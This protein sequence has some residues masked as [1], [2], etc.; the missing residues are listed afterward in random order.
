MMLK[1]DHFLSLI[2]YRTASSSIR[3][4]ISMGILS[5]FLL[6]NGPINIP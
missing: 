5:F 3:A 1:S 2:F 6:V 4:M